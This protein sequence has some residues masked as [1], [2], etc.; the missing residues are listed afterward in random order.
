M[1]ALGD[2]RKP[3]RKALKVRKARGQG[4]ERRREI[5]SAAKQLFLSE[6]YE[7]VT[8]RQLAERVGLSQ[9][10]LYVYFKNKEEILEEL[11][12]S[13][14]ERLAKRLDDIV[15]ERARGT[16]MLKRMLHGYIAFAL[17]NADEYQLTFMVTHASLKHHE[18][19]NLDRPAEEQPVAL[20]VFLTFRNQVAKLIADGN[21]RPADATVTTQM[22]W[23]ALHGLATLLITHP[24]FPWAD[25][26]H[27]IDTLVDT[28]VRG[29]KAPS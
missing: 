19:K 9:T 20:Q 2:M 7:T 12:Q 28:L 14:F 3:S 18:E 10:G 29:L 21:L 16:A 27:L 11:R 1:A 23:G 5:L 22:L 13:T 15:A 6:G 26:R 24:T 4:H 17:A 25:H 8:T